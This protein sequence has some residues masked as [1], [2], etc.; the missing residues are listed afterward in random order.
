M[1][2]MPFDD[3]HGMLSAEVIPASN[4]CLR[5]KVVV[6]RLTFYHL[7][8]ARAQLEVGILMLCSPPP[9]AKWAHFDG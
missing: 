7:A 5:F 9:A 3:R 2:R 6:M 8:L 1:G 4:K